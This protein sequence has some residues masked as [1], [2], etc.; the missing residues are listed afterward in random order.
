MVETGRFVIGGLWDPSIK[1][2]RHVVGAKRHDTLMGLNQSFFGRDANAIA[3][4]RA[5][6]DVFTSITR[7][8]SFW[9]QAASTPSSLM[10]WTGRSVRLRE[11]HVKPIEV[12]GLRL[13]RQRVGN[14]MSLGWGGGSL[15][16]RGGNDT[17][18]VGLTAEPYRGDGNDLFRP[19]VSHSLDGGAAND[20]L[21]GND[22]MT[23]GQGADLS[24]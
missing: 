10:T 12:R 3:R 13:N 5:R 17:R 14:R 7:P 1:T 23:G 18:Q 24:Y 16:G 2:R 22:L 6:H 15:E 4:R 20:T 11:P 19:A 21:V 8:M 9:T